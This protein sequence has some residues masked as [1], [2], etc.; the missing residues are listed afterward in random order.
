[1]SSFRFQPAGQGIHFIGQNVFVN[2]GQYQSVPVL[3]QRCVSVFDNDLMS[4]PVPPCIFLTGMHGASVISSACTGTTAFTLQ[5]EI[6]QYP[7]A[8]TQV[9]NVRVF[10]GSAFFH[11]Q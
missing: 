1:M 11:F 7:C 8:A 3:D 6:Y 4:D 10:D 9:Q 2:V 5:P